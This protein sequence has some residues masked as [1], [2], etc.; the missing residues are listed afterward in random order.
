MPVLS[1]GPQSASE[2][3]H[4]HVIVLAAGM[5]SSARHRVKPGGAEALEL[6]DMLSHVS[7]A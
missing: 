4:M 3:V 7:A 2:R 5:T 6:S 1:P